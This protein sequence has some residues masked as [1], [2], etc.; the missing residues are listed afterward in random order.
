MADTPETIE[1]DIGRRPLAV[2]L[3]NLLDLQQNKEDILSLDE[4]LD[5]VEYPSTILRVISRMLKA[6]GK[7]I[8]PEDLAAQCSIF[9][10]RALAGKF[11]ELL[12]ASGF[13]SGEAVAAVE[14]PGTGTSN[15][16]S[17][18]S[19]PKESAEETSTGSSVAIP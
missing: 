6:R 11:N 2:P 5:W 13:L 16:S 14:S 18:N 10:M 8:E 15:P 12:L 17:P 9:Q 1:F 7:P 4:S 3:L 19:P